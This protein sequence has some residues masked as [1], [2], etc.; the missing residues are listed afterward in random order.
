M[1][2]WLCCTCQVEESYL[3]NNNGLVKSHSGGHADGLHNTKVQPSVKVDPNKAVPTIEALIGE[4]S[5]GRVYFANL[6]NGKSVAVKK[7]DFSTKA[8]SNNEFLTQVAMV[9]TLKHD[10]LVELCG[11]CVEGN[12]RVLAYEFATMGSLHDI[13]HGIITVFGLMGRKGVQG[14]QPGPVLDWMQRV[15]I[16]VDA[17][18]G[19]ICTRRS[20][21]R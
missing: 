21:H 2:R 3:S 8:E 10:N 7:L 6:N 13:L 18:K 19:I 4:G 12:T 14:A 17:T 1:R 16:A 11:Y 15:K 9:S 20:N 5:Y